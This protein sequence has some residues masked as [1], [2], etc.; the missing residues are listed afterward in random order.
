MKEI[1]NNYNHVHDYMREVLLY[2]EH[3]NIHNIIY[4]NSENISRFM[5]EI[6]DQK[7]EKEITFLKSKK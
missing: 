6:L 1:G 2:A 4:E 5:N 7:S 3:Y